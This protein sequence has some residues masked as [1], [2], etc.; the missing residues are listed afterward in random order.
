MIEAAG[1]YLDFIAVHHMY[2]PDSKP[3]VLSWN[4]FRE[5]PDRTW[6]Q[7]MMAYQPHEN[8]L[9]NVREEIARKSDIG[10]VDRMSL[11]YSGEKPL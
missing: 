11:Y 2:N 4:A 1:E 8:K 6:D 3:P 5:D 9:R 7:L 10:R